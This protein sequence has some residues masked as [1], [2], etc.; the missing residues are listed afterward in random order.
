MLGSNKSIRRKRIGFSGYLGWVEVRF[1][2]DT[3]VV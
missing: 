2:K 3:S 1:N